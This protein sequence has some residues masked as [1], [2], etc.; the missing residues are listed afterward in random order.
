MTQV[1]QFA[2]IDRDLLLRILGKTN[3]PPDLYSGEIQ[4]IDSNIEKQENSKST[5]RTKLAAINQLLSKKRVLNKRLKDSKL[6]SS[7]NPVKIEHVNSKQAEDNFSESDPWVLRA[8]SGLGSAGRTNALNLMRYIHSSGD[9]AWDEKGRL[10]L[11]GK[12]LPSTN[13]ADLVSDAVRISKTRKP[14]HMYDIFA[15][16][17]EKINTPKGYIK[18]K[19][20][21]N[22]SEA[23]NY[24]SLSRTPIPVVG[25]SKISKPKKPP[26]QSGHGIAHW[27][28]KLL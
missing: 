13:I 25:R 15:R 21:L 12:I 10:V 26:F 18:N 16:E 22:P 7:S 1:K 8:T 14:A 24:Y 17:L 28:T 11:K 23:E 27:I 19:D 20:Y 4:E 6:G 9:V 3:P 5:A 2:V